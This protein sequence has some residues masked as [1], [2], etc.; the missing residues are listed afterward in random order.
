MFD[1]VSDI[2]SVD[3]KQTLNIL[4]EDERKVIEQRLEEIRQLFVHGNR[5]ELI[6][7][8]KTFPRETMLKVLD[9]SY[10][11]SKDGLR[12]MLATQ[13]IVGRDCF[14]DASQRSF[15]VSGDESIPSV[16]G[17]YLAKF[18]GKNEWDVIQFCNQKQ[19]LDS[20]KYESCL[21][22]VCILKNK[23]LDC[24]SY[25]KSK[26]FKREIACKI[27]FEEGKRVGEDMYYVF[28]YLLNCKKIYI[29]TEICGYNYY[30]NDNSTMNS[31]FSEKFFDTIELSGKMIEHLKCTDL[32]SYA[33]AHYYYEVCKVIEYICLSQNKN[34]YF[35]DKKKLKKTLNEC[36]GLFALKYLSR[37]N[38]LTVMLMKFSEKLYMFVYKIKN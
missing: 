31:K 12:E 11:M 9:Y 6:E 32:E 7:D 38:A 35:V 15:L 37:K 22:K 26:I 13:K 2:Y 36:K 25:S 34:E 4:P 10:H 23:G 29:D 5:Y 18:I 24:K 1:V 30:I 20:Y 8:K 27:K 19:A 3:W 33:R 16:I 14:Y 17:S 21:R 28:N